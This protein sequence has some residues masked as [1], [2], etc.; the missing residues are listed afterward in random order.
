MKGAGTGMFNIVAAPF[1]F[2]RTAAVAV[3]NRAVDN[4]HPVQRE[5]L[6]KE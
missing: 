4:S 1:L 3:I 5:M 2:Y 6:R